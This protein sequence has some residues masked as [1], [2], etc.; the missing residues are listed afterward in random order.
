MTLDSSPYPP[1]E[2]LKEK[3]LWLRR[4]LFSWG[5]CA[6]AVL[7]G[8]ASASMARLFTLGPS[9]RTILS[10]SHGVLSAEDL[11]KE[12]RREAEGAVEKTLR[13]EE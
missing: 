9:E 12:I 8:I 3:K 13:G 1:S 10:S 2:A 5:G 6:L 11:D 4:R 7:L